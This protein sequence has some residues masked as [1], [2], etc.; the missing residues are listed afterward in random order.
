MTEQE[1]LIFNE[2]IKL[3]AAFLN[4]LG[5]ALFAVGGLAPLFS[6]RNTDAWPTETIIVV[7][8]LCLVGAC[9]LHYSGSMVLKRLEP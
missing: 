3:L 2:R 7:S 5:I 8:C 4:G 9:A 1:K 6:A